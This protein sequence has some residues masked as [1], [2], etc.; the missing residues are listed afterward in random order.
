MIKLNNTT[1][2]PKAVYV[3]TRELVELQPGEVI[4]FEGD[5]ELVDVPEPMEV[6]V[7]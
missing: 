7:E 4:E 5:I 3:V 6:P 1:E 2:N